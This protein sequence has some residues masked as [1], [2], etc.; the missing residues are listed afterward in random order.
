LKSLG[1][2][3]LWNLNEPL[4]LTA[5]RFKG[6]Y[7]LSLADAIIAAFA[8]EN[9]AVLVHKDPEYEAINH[10]VRQMVLPYKEA[11]G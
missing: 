11:L 6:M 2:N 9:N 7:R 1:G 3:I 4:L 8:K 5:G 10:E